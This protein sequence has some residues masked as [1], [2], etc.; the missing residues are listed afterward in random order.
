[1]L[2]GKT[3]RSRIRWIWPSMPSTCE[4]VHYLD[5][6][7][8]SSSSNGNIFSLK[9]YWN[10]P[11]KLRSNRHWSFAST[12]DNRYELYRVYPKKLAITFPADF[13]IFTFFGAD[14]PGEVHCFWLFLRLRWSNG[15]FVHSNESTQKF[16]WNSL[17][18]NISKHCFEI[19]TRSRLWSTVSKRGT[20]L[21]DSFFIPNCSCKNWNHCAMWYVCGL[22]KRSCTFTCRS[23]KTISW[24][25]FIDDFWRSSLNWTSRTRCITCGCTTTFKFIHPITVVNAGADVLWT[26]SN[27]VLISFG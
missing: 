15:C 23:V 14:S 1:M 11:I 5:A 8:L 22:N 17:R 3:I 6:R 18:W 19:I 27:S 4:P 24:I 20:H 21:A 10:G 9:C 16:I 25:F 12:E 2:D 26:L 13:T 7:A